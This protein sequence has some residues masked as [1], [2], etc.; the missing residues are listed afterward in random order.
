VLNAHIG[1]D[2]RLFVDPNLLKNVSIDEFKNARADLETY[3]V[4]VIKLLKA[5]KKAGDIAWLEA[6]KR[7][8]FYESTVPLWDIHTRVN[9]GVVSARI[10][11]RFSPYAARK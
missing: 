1:I 6:R 11:R 3:F 8:I 2:N 9:L 5:S 7:L 10:L 4:P